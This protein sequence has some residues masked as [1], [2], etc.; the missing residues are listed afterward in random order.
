V[1]ARDV[2]SEI[3]AIISS[4]CVVMFCRTGGSADQADLYV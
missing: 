1:I 2:A 4:F 3:K